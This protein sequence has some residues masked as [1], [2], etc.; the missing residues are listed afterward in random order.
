MCSS[1]FQPLALGVVQA[2]DLSP[3]GYPACVGRTLALP[4]ME[5]HAS[6]PAEQP[7]GGS[8]VAARRQAVLSEG[9]LILVLLFP[10]RFW[11]CCTSR[12]KWQRSSSS[13]WPPPHCS[14]WP[15]SSPSW[16]RGTCSSPCWPRSAAALRPQVGWGRVWF[17]SSLFFG[18]SS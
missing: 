16:Q 1:F 10:C 8:L 9:V 14:P 2:P 18:H 6:C 3:E 11:T 7:M 13:V 17:F 5:C 12:T 4:H 15:G